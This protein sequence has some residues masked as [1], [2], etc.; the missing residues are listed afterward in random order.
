[1]KSYAQIAGIDFDKTFAPVVRIESVRYSDLEIYVQQPE[2]FVSK[3]YPREVLR[4]NKS[5]YGLKQAPRI[6]YL[7]LCSVILSLDFISLETDHS[8]YF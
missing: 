7:L 4:L 6:W 3:T 2:G 8:I 5:L 1:M